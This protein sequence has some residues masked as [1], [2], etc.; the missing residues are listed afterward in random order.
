M[1]NLVLTAFVLSYISLS[2][3]A[4]DIQRIALDERI[5]IETEGCDTNELGSVQVVNFNSIKGVCRPI[6]CMG[7]Q[8][9]SQYQDFVAKVYLTVEGGGIN[10]YHS[11]ISFAK[12]LNSFQDKNEFEA[13]L[14]NLVDS[15]VCKEAH[16]KQDMKGSTFRT[17]VIK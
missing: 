6:I 2:A 1:K 16:Y 14:K 8:T 9:S 10:K 15:K 4:I 7:H 13:Q 17:I 11:T 3:Q 12:K 5:M